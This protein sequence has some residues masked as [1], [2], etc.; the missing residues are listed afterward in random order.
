MHRKKGEEVKESSEKALIS[1]VTSFNDKLFDQIVKSRTQSSRRLFELLSLKL[2]ENM[3][4]EDIRS[5]WKSNKV[6]KRLFCVYGLGKMGREKDLE[7]LQEL[8]KEKQLGSKYKVAII[9]SLVRIGSRYGKGD[10][11]MPLLMSGPVPIKRAI[12]DALETPFPKLKL[13]DI[14]IH[15]GKFPRETGKA[16]R[17]LAT[18]QDLPLLKKTLKRIKLDP[19]AREIVLAVC[20]QGGEDEFDFLWDLFTKCQHRIDFWN[21]GV[22]FRAMANLV[23]KRHLSLLTKIIEIE[24]FWEYY[25]EDQRPGRQIPAADFQNVYFIRRLTGI[26]YARIAGR[27]QFGKLK[28]LLGHN[29]WIICDAAA[30]KI[31]KLAKPLDFSRL[32]EN[33]ISSESDN[34]AIIKVLCSLDKKFHT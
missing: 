13:Q 20:D 30:D 33:A 27:S 17:R 4:L 12:L 25:P 29:Y 28:R 19:T 7:W 24:E 9:K 10:E 1:L 14:L 2:S 34:D 15:Y 8:S 3:T 11:F 21:A 22:V 6:S 26:A 32:L 23:R 18:K 31:I 5:M 16:V